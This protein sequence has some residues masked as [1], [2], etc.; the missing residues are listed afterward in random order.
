MIPIVWI[1]CGFILLID[2]S[3]KKKNPE[4]VLASKARKRKA[5][6]TDEE[7]INRVFKCSIFLGIAFI[8]LGVLWIIVIG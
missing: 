2:A 5:N 1:I 8:F 4:K 3:I 6:L 7:Y